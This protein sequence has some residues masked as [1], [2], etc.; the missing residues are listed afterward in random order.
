MSKLPLSKLYKKE[1]YGDIVLDVIICV[2]LA[3]IVVVIVFTNTFTC[4]YVS[5]ESMEPNI[6]DADYVLIK[7]KTPTY[8]D[9]VVVDATYS[10][11]DDFG[12]V[13]TSTNRLIK[14]VIALGGD[15]LYLDRGELYIKYA[16]ENDFVRVEEKY[17]DSDY[18][19]PFK[20][21][22]T[23][24][25]NSLGLLDREGHTV[26]DGCMFL[27]GDNRD[28]SSDSRGRYGDVSMKSLVGVVTE[29]S[30]SHI[31]SVTGWYTFWNKKVP[32]FFGF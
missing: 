4:I 13:Y 1:G 16:G 11:T 24:P 20:P 29:W 15:T 17:L 28:I 7:D 8:G 26:A 30:L 6:W 31:D 22:N 21:V 12:N 32:E 2:L 25:V 23:F 9:V 18:N 10:Y 19:D 5:G 27:M 3:L 14:R